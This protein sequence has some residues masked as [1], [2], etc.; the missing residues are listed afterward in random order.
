MSLAVSSSSSD[1]KPW[2]TKNCL[3]NVSEVKVFPN[4]R[5]AALRRKI[6]PKKELQL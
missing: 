6:S 4:G 1:L 2:K 5:V 3:L